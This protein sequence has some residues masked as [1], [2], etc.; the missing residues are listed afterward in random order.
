MDI[1]WQAVSGGSYSG[2]LLAQN[3][4]PTFL[5][6]GYAGISTRGGLVSGDPLPRVWGRIRVLWVYET[7]SNHLED[8]GTRSVITLVGVR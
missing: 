4:Q 5:N 8:W 2:Y 3:C 6:S 1:E 7:G